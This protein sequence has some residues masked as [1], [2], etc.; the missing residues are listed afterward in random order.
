MNMS[1]TYRLR[2]KSCVG[3]IID[4]HKMTD[5]HENGTIMTQFFKLKDAIGNMDM[6]SISERDVLNI[7]RATNAF[8]AQLQ[9]TFQNGDYGPVHQ[10]VFH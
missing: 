8:L 3:I 6:G 5:F 10:G 1:D 7:E 4:I 2:L 9:S